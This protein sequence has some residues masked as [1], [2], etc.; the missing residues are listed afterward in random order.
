MRVTKT[1][2][3][4]DAL[5]RFGVSRAAMP[6]VLELA[7]LGALAVPVAHHLATADNNTDRVMSGV[8]LGGLG[9]L[10]VPEVMHLTGH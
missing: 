5:S 10:A 7:G 2:G 3:V 8:E 4:A 6:R 9:L 1:A